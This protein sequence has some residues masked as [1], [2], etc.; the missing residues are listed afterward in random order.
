MVAVEV[1]VLRVWDRD[2]DG[3]SSCYIWDLRAVYEHRVVLG[4]WHRLPRGC[5]RDL[6]VVRYKNRVFLRS[7]HRLPSGGPCRIFLLIFPRVEISHRFV[8]VKKV[9]LGFFQ[10]YNILERYLLSP[11]FMSVHN[12]VELRR[13][14]IFSLQNY[15]LFRSTLRLFSHTLVVSVYQSVLQ[16]PRL[17]RCQLNHR[18]TDP[19]NCPLVWISFL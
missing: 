3:F 11:N 4:S 12:D 18:V 8:L 9:G 7:R 5:V 10:L 6:R 15:Q 19:H 14:R 13:R 2:R 16:R 1:R 17:P